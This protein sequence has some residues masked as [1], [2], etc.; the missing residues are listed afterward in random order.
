[1]PAPLILHIETATDICSVAVTS[2]PEL[3]SLVESGEER[4]HSTLLNNYIRTALEKANTAVEQLDGVAVG[5]GPGSYTGLRIGVST[6]K[7]IAYAL[8]VPLLATGTLRG[9]ASGFSNGTEMKELSVKYGRDVLLAPMLDA[10][11]MEVYTEFFTPV[12]ETVRPIAAD[13]V[14]KGSYVEFLDQTHMAFFGNGSRKC[15]KI[16]DHP[17]ALFFEGFRPSASHMIPEVLLR[18]EK[19]QFEDVAYFEPFYLKDFIATRPRKKVI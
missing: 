12:L 8:R 15:R 16:L 18:F 11:R 7:G 1:M 2:G 10:R 14:D 4:A 17:H 5:K 9:M 19:K 3:L 13:I 6:A